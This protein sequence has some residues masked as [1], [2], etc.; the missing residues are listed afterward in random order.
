M[1]AE[2]LFY[3]AIGAAVLIWLAGKIKKRI[4]Q[5]VRLSS[6]IIFLEEYLNYTARQRWA[7]EECANK[8]D[9]IKKGQEKLWDA[10]KQFQKNMDM[11]ANNDFKVT[12]EETHIILNA[13]EIVSVVHLM[14]AAQDGN[15]KYQNVV[16]EVEEGANEDIG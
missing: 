14:Q 8:D 2:V 1:N 3:I 9:V 7:I 11:L 6:Q 15:L 16:E 10:A 12:P 4:P 5:T 13:L